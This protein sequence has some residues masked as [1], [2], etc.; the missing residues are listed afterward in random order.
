VN[1]P[2]TDPLET[3]EAREADGQIQIGA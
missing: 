2:A 1:P 3:Y